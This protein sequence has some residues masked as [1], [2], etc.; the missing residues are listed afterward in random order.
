MLNPTNQSCVCP[1]PDSDLD[2]LGLNAKGHLTHREAF[3][4]VAQ[5]L[6]EIAKKGNAIVIGQGGAALCRLM[7]NC[8]HFRIEASLGWRIASLAKRVN[9]PAAEARA[10]IQ[11]N[12][13]HREHFLNT[14]VGA[15]LSDL[16]LYDAVF[17]NEHHSAE[18]MAAAIAAYVR[19]AWPDQGSR[20]M[21]RSA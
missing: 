5:H 2:L 3:G 1:D 18:Q 19:Q 12:G 21:H 4:A 14:C 10:L 16:S 9:L 15:E 13:A 20:L 17:N 11:R 8:Y 6:R 7:E